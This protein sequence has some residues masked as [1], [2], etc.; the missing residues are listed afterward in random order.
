MSIDRRRRR[1]SDARSSYFHV[2]T[3]RLVARRLNDIYARL[4]P[5]QC[6]CRCCPPPLSS[7]QLATVS[8][9]GMID[10]AMMCVGRSAR[11]QSVSRAVCW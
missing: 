9:R 1:F 10:P 7:T 3:T 4:T 5:H 8:C 6:S 2:R 11:S